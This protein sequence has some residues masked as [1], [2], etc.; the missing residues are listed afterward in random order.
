M[1]AIVCS[2]VRFVKFY[3]GRREDMLFQAAV[4]LVAVFTAIHS[5]GASAKPSTFQGT[6][7]HTHM[8]ARARA[9]THSHFLYLSV[10]PSHCLCVSVPLSLLLLHMHTRN[11]HTSAKSSNFKKP[12][13]Y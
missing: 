12:C 10:S 8:H 3:R 2:M 6:C 1:R 13:R 9:H 4:V 5:D 11:A 7:A